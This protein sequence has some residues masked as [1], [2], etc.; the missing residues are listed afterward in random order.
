M[1]APTPKSLVIRRVQGEVE[2]HHVD[3]MQVMHNSQYLRFFE[4]GRLSLLEEVVPLSWA[5]EHRFATPVVMNHCDYL[6]PARFGDR[7]VITTRHRKLQR[8]T[9]KF[10]FDHSMSNARTKVELARGRTAITVID[11]ETGRLVKELPEDIWGRYRE[12]S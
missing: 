11:F 4:K 7:L 5:V 6:A 10:V 9:G 2:F 1:N 12:L 3:M 8:W